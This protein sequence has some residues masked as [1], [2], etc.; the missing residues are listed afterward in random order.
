MDTQKQPKFYYGWVM[1]AVGIL[2]VAASIGLVA[3]TFPIYI[4]PVG[5]ELGLSRSQMSINQTLF[6]A[7]MMIVQFFWGPVFSRLKLIR[8]MRISAGITCVGY[9]L[10]AFAQS[11][12]QFISISAVLS[13]TMAFLS[14]MP[15]TVIINNWFYEKRGLA[16]GITFMGSGI[17]GMLFNALGGVLVASVGWRAT[18]MIYTGVL[19]VLL[20]PTV[21][22]LLKLKPE[23]M[24][25]LPYGQTQLQAERPP[26]GLTLSQALGTRVFLPICLCSLVTGFSNNSL[27]ATITP[28]LQQLGY[29]GVFA[30]S[31][32]SA[33]LAAL[34]AGKIV[35]GQVTDRLGAIK[36]T[37]LA[38]SAIALSAC[39]MLGAHLLPV[40]LCTVPVMGLGN[41]FGSVAFPLISR[42]VFGEKD[43]AAIT[44]VLSAMSGIGSTVGPLLCGLI[45]DLNGSY[46]LAYVAMIVLL[47]P[48]GILMLRAMRRHIAGS[49]I[50]EK[51]T[52]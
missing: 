45:F 26:E 33:Y 40:A 14:W 49:P 15:F 20:L 24:G 10:Y 12:W 31:V 29:S 4:V 5:Q 37:A 34:A 52:P 23:D 50:P 38:L 42:S 41:A 25:L 27:N 48:L 39:G 30:A 17:G 43:H 9:L 32:A 28:H 22:F 6:A 44:G 21:F 46:H 16:L 36:A 13:L 18:V 47:I 2:V 8:T 35:L 1:V 7:G 19:C 3:N 51:T 11:F